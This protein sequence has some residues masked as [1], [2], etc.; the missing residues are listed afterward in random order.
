M[1]CPGLARSPNGTV[2]ARA[3][4]RSEPRGHAE[5][6]RSVRRAAHTSFV[7]R[8]YVIL[9]LRGKLQGWLYENNT[10]LGRRGLVTIAHRR[11]TL[12]FVFGPD[13]YCEDGRFSRRMFVDMK[14][15]KKRGSGLTPA[16]AHPDRTRMAHES[17]PAFNPTAFLAKV[18]SGKTILHCEKKTCC[19]HKAMPLTPSFTFRRDG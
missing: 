2:G 14:V 1:E 7:A 5:S 15:M 16:P 10:P 18:G 4:C 13:Y 9:P 3:P 17:S 8:A 19:F 12:R 11:S 6:P